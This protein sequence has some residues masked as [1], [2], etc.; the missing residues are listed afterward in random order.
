MRWLLPGPGGRLATFAALAW[1]AQPSA[2]AA[3]EGALSTIEGEVT[4]VAERPGE[5]ELAV[6]AVALRREEGAE[7]QE[8]LLAP[9]EALEEIGFAVEVGDHLKVRV[10]ADTGP[11]ARAQRVLNLTRSSM[12][13]LR[14]LDRTPLWSGAGS[15]QGGSV[16][17]RPD[18]GPGAHPGNGPG[19][20]P[21]APGGGPRR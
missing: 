7:P 5:G 15:W 18:L 17:G 12:V 21:G 2:L 14:T 10:F 4:A 9:H 20:P 11:P 16:R 6:V 1:I 8:V 3:A 13:R 19:G